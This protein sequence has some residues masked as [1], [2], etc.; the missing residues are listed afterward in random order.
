MN[1]ASFLRDLTVV[2]LAAAAALLLFKRLRWPPVLG[3]LAVGLLVGPN[4]PPFSFI[5][6]IHSLEALSEVGVVFLLF[7]L[8]VEF[9][10]GRLA[11]AG[12]RAVLCAVIEAGLLLGGALAIG[13]ALGR[14]VVESL[15]L[16]GIA[17]LASTA[18]VA[19][20][21]LESDKLRTGAWS[22]LSAGMLIAEDVVAV[23][24]I[25]L[26]ASLGALSSFSVGI[27]FGLVVRLATLAIILLVAGL[28]ILPRLM[29]VVERSGMKEIRTLLVVGTCFGVS[30]LT[31]TLGF[32]AALGA[33]LA[34]ALVSESAGGKRL[35][36]TVEPFRDV[37][38]AVFFVAVGMMIEPAWV[39]ANWRPA[40]AIA[41][42][43]VVG[44]F[45]ANFAALTAVGADR[46]SAVQASAA[47]L[48]IGEFS[49]LLAQLAQRER[50]SDAPLY[51][52]AV[53]LCLAT[54]TASA[55]LLP[56]TLARPEAVDRAF[57]AF[58]ARWFDHYRD[59]IRRAAMPHR[60]ALVWSLTRPSLIQILLNA[61]VISGLF[62]AAGGLKARVDIETA[63]PGA[64]W[65]GVALV[66][67]PLLLALW[68][69]TQAV[70]LIL[71]EAFTTGP[72]DDR[73]PAEARPRLTRLILGAATL[74][75]GWWYLSLS[76]ALLPRGRAAAV[77]LLIILGAGTALWR[78]ANRLYAKMQAGLRDTL[79]RS[80]AQ[81]EAGATI[82]SHLVEQEEGV[83]VSTADLSA[84]AKAVGRSL[85][86][87]DVRGLSGASVLQVSRRGQVLVAPSAAMRFE[88]GDNVLLVGSAEQVAAAKALLT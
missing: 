27:A 3:Y 12:I 59:T 1:A 61:L 37:F 52:V 34:G 66:T 16:G 60:V 58:A 32:S 86:E 19:R 81:P 5:A 77:P 29:G 53:L 76:F 18:I 20:T 26:F 24:L 68:R 15:L 11:Q 41:A 54:T 40:L 55:V 63:V 62:I 72:E 87:L 21:L 23:L 65:A 79:A 51:P 36:D 67:L 13:L 28:L 75:V 74:L 78:G 64:L 31:H 17:A 2:L 39:L 85:A 33:F 47:M 48:P 88:A 70:A 6:D 9:N 56:R 22:E 69:K 7:A 50:L 46:V 83:T 10:L 38:G 30:F 45:G 44:R 25:G 35:H 8:G 84:G 43:V 14:P 4:T 82:V 57:G 71:L 80:S 73:P 49:F 42:A